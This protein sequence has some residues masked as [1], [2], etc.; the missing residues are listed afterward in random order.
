MDNN[1]K[2]I[3]P[4]CE[5]LTKPEEISALREYLKQGIQEN[6]ESLVTGDE[7]PV[8][9]TPG[10]PILAEKH[11]SE[12]KIRLVDD[13]TLELNKGKVTLD[14][15]QNTELSGKVD[16]MPG[17][18]E[19]IEPSESLVGLAI[20]QKKIELPDETVE[21]KD[22]RKLELSEKRLEIS[23]NKI[24]PKKSLLELA[25]EGDAQI[26]EDSLELKVGEG[27]NPKET[28]VNLQGTEKITSLS[29]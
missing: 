2:K 18:L 28:M 12:K 16:L 4:G 25:I 14:V 27:V 3:M 8:L 21:L 11:I 10:E 9:K 22:S 5:K 17:D 29:D 13:R 1:Q 6:E 19:E 26:K 15:S 20:N 23:E 24:Q 7:N